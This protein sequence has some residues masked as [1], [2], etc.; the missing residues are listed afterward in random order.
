MTVRARTESYRFALH[1]AL[2]ILFVAPVVGIVTK[3]G[4]EKIKTYTA[5]G[6]EMLFSNLFIAIGGGLLF[7][8]TY[9][10][11]NPILEQIQTRSEEH[12]SELQSRF[13]LVCRLLLEQ[14]NHDVFCFDCV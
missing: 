12:T 11:V 9:Y 8:I 1:D 10:W 5:A 2:P 13:D 14:K 6:F 3:K 7:L 4:L